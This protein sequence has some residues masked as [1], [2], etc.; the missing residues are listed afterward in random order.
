MKRLPEKYTTTKKKNEYTPSL[1]HTEKHFPVIQP[2]VIVRVFVN[3]AVPTKVNRC[4]FHSIFFFF[5]FLVFFQQL[6]LLICTHL[7]PCCHS[8]GFFAVNVSFNAGLSLR[9]E[10][11]VPKSQGTKCHANCAER[12]N[13]LHLLDKQTHH[14][15]VM[16]LHSCSALKSNSAT[17]ELCSELV[18][19]KIN[20]IFEL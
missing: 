6:V 20:T 9:Y 19:I 3:L 16:T 4:Y 5:I 14:W 1:L 2:A 17:F 18:W 8:F 7:S 15:T 13:S 11:G 10:N 12:C